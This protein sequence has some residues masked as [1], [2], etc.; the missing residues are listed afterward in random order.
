[1]TPDAQNPEE[2]SREKT[3]EAYVLGSPM[4]ALS[5]R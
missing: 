2:S 4:T 1:M 5:Q 3:Q